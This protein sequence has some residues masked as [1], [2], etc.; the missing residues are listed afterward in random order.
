MTTTLN[1]EDEL[2]H[3]AEEL[4]GIHEKSCVLILGLEARIQ[5]I[6]FSRKKTDCEQMFGGMRHLLKGI[7]AVTS[8]AELKSPS[9]YRESK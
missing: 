4:I 2:I 8:N 9:Q 1:I 6:V 7:I 5:R 3:K